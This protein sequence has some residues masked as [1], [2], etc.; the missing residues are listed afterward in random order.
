MTNPSRNP[1]SRLPLVL[2]GGVALLCFAAGGILAGLFP[3]S[4]HPDDRFADIALASLALGLLGTVL[5]WPLALWR[6]GRITWIE[7]LAAMALPLAF[8]GGGYC[9]R[10]GDHLSARILWLTA[11]VLFLFL[12]LRV[13]EHRRTKPSL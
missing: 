1:H 11:F 3:S 10:C 9:E 13:R 5:S 6:I 4:S 7:A 8:A 12:A 2:A